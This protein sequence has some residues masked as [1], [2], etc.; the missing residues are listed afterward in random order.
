M[1]CDSM[2]TT[3]KVH[4]EWVYSW[5]IAWENLKNEGGVG[6][7]LESSIWQDLMDHLIWD[8]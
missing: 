7:H 5:E 8:E 3:P 6:K 1:H 4:L 2:S